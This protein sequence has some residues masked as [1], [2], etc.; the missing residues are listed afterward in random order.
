M[1]V[2]NGAASEDAP[3]RQRND[4]APRPEP[5]A[6]VAL[7][8]PPPE[9]PREPVLAPVLPPTPAAPVPV[10]LAPVAPECPS[11]DPA[12]VDDVPLLLGTDAVPML[13]TAPIPAVEPFELCG[14][15]AIAVVPVVIAPGPLTVPAVAAPPANPATVGLAP[16]GFVLVSVVLPGGALG[17]CPDAGVCAAFGKVTAPLL[18]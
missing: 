5:A 15:L 12:V 13:T 9:V 2:R 4:G 10:V 3:E 1:P 6:A 17:F 7:L 14:T 8:V 11:P 18:V 16:V